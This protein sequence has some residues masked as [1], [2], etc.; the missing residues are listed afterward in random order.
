MKKRKYI[1]DRMRAWCRMYFRHPLPNLRT[2]NPV[3]PKALYDYFGYVVKPVPF[4]RDEKEALQGWPDQ[5]LPTNILS[6]ARSPSD[7]TRF[8]GKNPVL[9]D[10]PARCNLCDLYKRTL[11]C[12]LGNTLADGS[13][14]CDNC[15]YIIIKSPK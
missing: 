1:F 11:P 7:V 3:R 15:K 12:P 4:S 2:A 10:I 13:V 9:T 5:A 6:A 14:A 8:Y